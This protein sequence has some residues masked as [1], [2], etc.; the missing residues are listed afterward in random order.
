MS[1]VINF[2]TYVAV[3]EEERKCIKKHSLLSLKRDTIST[4][5]HSID[6]S[7]GVS[8]LTKHIN[9]MNQLVNQENVVDK[10]LL[11]VIYDAIQNYSEDIQTEIKKIENAGCNLF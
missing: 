5:L 11:K 8:I 2:Q 6:N 10:D 3:K 1:T 4:L 9:V 7:L